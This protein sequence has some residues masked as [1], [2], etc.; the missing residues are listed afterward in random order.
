[1]PKREAQRGTHLLDAIVDAAKTNVE[2]ARQ[3]AASAATNIADT[4]AGKTR[5][6]KSR[7]KRSTKKAAPTTRRQSASTAAKRARTPAK[8][9]RRKGE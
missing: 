6:R 9:R 5:K 7:S 2:F 3:G 4:I 8:K 1:M